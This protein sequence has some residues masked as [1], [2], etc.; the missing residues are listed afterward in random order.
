MPLSLDGSSGI[1]GVINI[2]S[3]GSVLT[4]VTTVAAGSTSAP[5]ISPSGDSNTGIFFPSAD[6]V[7]IAEGGTESARFTSTGNV[8]IANGNLVF[9]TAGTGIDFSATANSSGTMTSE[10]LSDYE[11]GTWTPTVRGSSTVGTATYAVQQG[12]YVKIGKVVYISG[13]VNWSSGTGS[14]DLLVA[15]LPFTVSSTDPSFE[16]I[17]V[18]FLD[19]LTLPA[20]SVMTPNASRNTTNIVFSTY[21]LG[22]GSYGTV[23]YDAAVNHLRFSGFYFA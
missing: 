7:A 14:G 15:G 20:S 2:Q 5:S 12:T 18:S 1:T 13:Y 9:S 4:G 22:G 10:L 17:S 19:G 16:A 6:T 23:A 21:P 11:E 8:Q 3:T